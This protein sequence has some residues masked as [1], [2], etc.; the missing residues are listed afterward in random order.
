VFSERFCQGTSTVM[1]GK[2]ACV[3]RYP[4]TCPLDYAKWATQYDL[5]QYKIV[6]GCK[7]PHELD[8]LKWK[9]IGRRRRHPL[10]YLLMDHWSR[11][12]QPFHSMLK[13][14][15]L[16]LFQRLL[17]HS[18]ARN[19]ISTHK[20]SVTVLCLELAVYIHM[21]WFQFNFVHCRCT[22]NSG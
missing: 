22:V 14:W 10:S 12:S 20:V 2:V 3:R 19:G 6:L 18:K 13:D 17:F 1:G 21:S 9:A 7:I 5:R 15:K 11:Q 16:S 4:Y 8:A